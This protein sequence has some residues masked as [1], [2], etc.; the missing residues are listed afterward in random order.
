[1]RLV[2]ATNAAVAA[3]FWFAATAGHAATSAT[4]WNL[5]WTGALGV[6]GLW[7]ITA[8]SNHNNIDAATTPGFDHTQVNVSVTGSIVIRNAD[9]TTFTSADVIGVDVTVTGN[10]PRV[11]SF[12]MTEEQL[13]SGVIE[14]TI[15][16][17]IGDGA[18]ISLTDF[19]LVKQGPSFFPLFGCPASFAASECGGAFGIVW[20]EY[21]DSGP[22]EPPLGFGVTYG[23]LLIQ[24]GFS[25]PCCAARANEL[26]FF[27]LSPEDALKSIKLTYDGRREFDGDDLPGLPPE[28]PP[29]PIP[30]PAS[31]PLLAAGLGALGLFRRRR[32]TGAS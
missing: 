8:S 26:R 2:F 12:S 3:S 14:G 28:L 11:Q 15:N 30:L 6:N 10:G 21:P 5:Q 20:A 23:R 1:M 29:A 19:R 22:I 4:A 7:A 24:D 25:D 27:Y 31:L 17:P 18:T 13:R 16:G 9:S 32:R